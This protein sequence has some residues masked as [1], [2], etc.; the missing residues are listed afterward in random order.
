MAGAAAR[1]RMLRRPKFIV[2]AAVSLYV[3]ALAVAWMLEAGRARQREATILVSAETGFSDIVNGEIDAALRYVGGAIINTFGCVGAPQT[4]E[5]MRELA[6]VFNL[7]EVNVV[8][9]DGIVLGSNVPSVLGY[10]FKLNPLTR[11]FMML[12]NATTTIVSHPFRAG[13]ANPHMVC[14]YHGIAFPGHGAFLQLGLTVDRLRQNMYSYTDAEADR[15]LRDWHFSIVGWYERA[16]RAPDFAPGRFVRRRDAAHGGWIACR[17]FNYLGFRYAALLPESYC[18]SHRNSAF[19]NTA[20]VLGALLFVFTYILVRLARTSANLLRLHAAA[21]ARTAADLALARTIQMSA[22]P[23]SDGAFMERMDFSLTASCRPAREV[24]GDFYDYFHLPGNRLA[25]LVADVSGKGIP[26]SLFMMEAKN[27]LKSCLVESADLAEAV[28]EANRR[29]CAGNKAEMFVTAWIGVLDRSGTFEYVNAG[30]NRPFLRRA[31]GAVEKVMGKG[32]LFLGMFEDATYR[33]NVLRLER[34]DTLY[35]YTDGITEAMNEKGEL[36]GE[37]RLR[38]TLAVKADVKAAVAA[39]VAGAEQS[40]DIT[41]VTI[42][43]HGQPD[44]VEREFAADESS[45]EPALAFIREALAGLDAKVVAAMLNAADEVTSNIVNYSGAGR[46]RVEVMRT[47]D[48][49]RLRFADDGTPYNPLLHADPD[50]HASIE[51]RPIGGLG[52]VVVKRLTDRMSYAYENGR[53]ELTLI[54]K[55]APRCGAG[56]SER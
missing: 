18:N 11:E 53:N 21:D 47:A 38:E 19:A 35:L 56:R 8:D 23:S 55:T 39:F 28:A 10:D 17:Y 13:V 43:W 45:L 36:F 51:N 16:D 48:R 14:K 3:I 33:V 6:A 12:T 31:D 24:G 37:R 2:C 44:A 42:A 20:V 1:W 7:D 27:V 41:D 29:L 22:L 46:Y 4:L 30:H 15:I 34:G 40:D 50:T 54:R 25:F 9:G 5:R 26:G 49:L 52:L 32:G